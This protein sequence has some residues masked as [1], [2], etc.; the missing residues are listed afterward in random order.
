MEDGRE[1]RVLEAE[2]LSF[3]V[4]EMDLRSGELRKS[5]SL[6]K[7][8]PQPFQILA[9]LARRP[10]QVVT[11]EEIR[12]A[13][14]GDGTIVDFDQRL[15]SCITQIRAVLGDDAE[16]PRYV[17]TLPRRGYRWIGPAE[18]VQLKDTPRV[19]QLVSPAEKPELPPSA[20]GRV[21]WR[22]LHALLTLGAFAACAWLLYAR[23]PGADS[24][25][26]QRAT[27]RRGYVAQARFAAGGEIVFSG[28]FEGSPLGLLA[29]R[30]PAPDARRI[31]L[32]PPHAWFVGISSHGEAAY[33][34]SDTAHAT[35]YRVPTAGGAPR[36][37]L[38]RVLVAD[39]MPDGREFAVARL[40]G[41]RIRVELPIGHV[42]GHVDG[43][44]HLRVSPDG[45]RVALLEHP[46][47]GDDA[48]HVVV[49]DR[50]GKRTQL[51]GDWASIAGL[52]WSPKGDEVWFTATKAGSDL[53]LHAVRLDGRLRK[54]LAGGARLVLH[55]I[56]G[57]GR[58]L[59]DR[60]TMRIGSVF[61]RE[62]AVERDVSWFDATSVVSL[63][64]DGRTL[65]QVESGE[66]GGSEYGVYL[67][68]GE[69]RPPTR[70]GTGRATDLSPDGK[71]V[72][73][74]PTR[75]PDRIEMLPTGPGEK[76][77]LR[78]AGFERFEW[79]GFFPDGSRLIFVG[80]RGGK[81]GWETHVSDLDGRVTTC[82]GGFRIRRN[83]LSPDGSQ[84]ARRGPDA[85]VLQRIGVQLAEPPPQRGA[86]DTPRSDKG[87]YTAEIPGIGGDI[88]QF[89]DA[90]GRFLY[91][92]A[93]KHAPASVER[94]DIQTGRR[95]PWKTLM[96]AD[97]V[98][99]QSIMDVYGTPDAKAW[100]YSYIRR[101]SELHVLE[102]LR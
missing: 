43:P 30:P 59:V 90:S 44:S 99:V 93:A 88:P 9:L 7:I 94:L 19:L 89:W 63:S 71:W 3:G 85:Y 46:V 64:R 100:A 1:E 29:V 98:G 69:G 51:G 28:A 17:E 48:G 39:F 83:W 22:K 67:R 49:F 102:G 33:L 31:E 82:I 14:W 75:Q 5:G 56:A 61:G 73:S 87:R 2:R 66:A 91:V 42:V 32:P 13:V 16:V 25:S 74:I 27:H 8:A 18:V 86:P 76:R 52:A 6:V 36:A 58:V 97:P 10:R 24:V 21:P 35:L 47:R 81:D 53:D 11:R 78:P 95:E 77:V 38:E 34:S 68:S 79:A 92:R 23:P 12:R 26:W 54:V 101:L 15:N 70:L 50:A 37:V 40:D 57:D 84:L 4:F 62:G 55:D 60:G 80:R 65:V 20:A 96:P 72:L 41:G 45:Q